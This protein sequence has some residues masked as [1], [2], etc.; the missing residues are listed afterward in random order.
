MDELNNLV[1]I[2]KD[3]FKDHSK[4]DIIYEII[5]YHSTRTYRHLL[6]SIFGALIYPP[7]SPLSVEEQISFNKIVL[8]LQRASG[9]LWHT[10]NWHPKK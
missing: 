9:G 3:Y 5:D 7:Y 4:K 6:D 1:A 8:D 10:V 2:F